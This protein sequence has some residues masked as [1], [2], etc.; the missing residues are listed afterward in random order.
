MAP[1]GDPKRAADLGAELTRHLTRETELLAQ[2]RSVEASANG[3]TAF[4]YFVRLIAE[5]EHVHNQLFRD[6]I[7]ALQEQQGP[8]AEAEGSLAGDAQKLSEEISHLLT[9]ESTHAKALEMLSRRLKL[10]GGN[11]M[12]L[13]L[14]NAMQWDIGKHIA[15]LSSIRDELLA[16]R[17]H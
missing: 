5:D 15:I 14:V 8:L 17:E 16:Q 9:T 12:W 10:Q 6:L 4:S 11:R 3:G 13:V 7:A 2:Y 1:R